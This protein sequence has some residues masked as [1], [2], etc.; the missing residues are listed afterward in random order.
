MLDTF[1][2]FSHLSGLKP[3]L[4]KSEISGIGVLKGVQVVLFG[5]R[6]I[7]L[8]NDMSKILGTHFFCNEKLKEGKKYDEY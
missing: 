3:N 6:G 5:T 4:T 2:L 7:D 8:I 1:Y